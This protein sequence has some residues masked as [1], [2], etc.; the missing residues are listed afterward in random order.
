MQREKDQRIE[1]SL[2]QQAMER[3]TLFEAQ[4]ENRT[5][6]RIQS[7]VATEAHRRV[8]ESD[9]EALRGRRARL[10]ALREAE[11]S[12][13][14]KEM[15]SIV[16]TPAERKERLRAKA[17]ALKERREAERKAFVDEK[18]QQQWRESCDEAR[19]LDSAALL[20]YV[21]AER[22]KEIDDAETRKAQKNAE[23][24]AFAEQ[25]K[26]RMDD[27]AERERQDAEARR[28]A[29]LATKA[30]LDEQVRLK[31]ERRR[32]LIERM[33]GE[34]EEELSELAAAQEQERREKEAREAEARRRGHEVREFNAN[35]LDLREKRAAV[36]REQ[37]L[38]L[39]RYNMEREE[40]QL[41]RERAKKDAE[42]AATRQYH[43]YLRDL[44]VKEHQDESELDSIRRAEED[45][46]WVK[47]DQE[48][49]AQ[50]EARR[51]LMDI[52][53][54]GRREQISARRERDA[55]AAR[56]EAEQERR[57][58]E[59]L[60]KGLAQ[61]RARAEAR[62]RAQVE[63][64]RLLKEQIALR[65]RARQDGRARERKEAEDWRSEMRALD[66]RA[67]SQAGE[68]RLHHPKRHT[69]WYS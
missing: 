56:A 30:D 59:D 7:R 12:E 17:L 19:T 39:L 35:R 33:R 65:E 68:I 62:R 50:A 26:A 45:R 57:D 5:D 11:R 36:E 3:K 18:L 38:L 40:A 64:D 66:A 4:W 23:D 28:S 44:M 15:Q 14:V 2:R 1:E 46:I 60:Q 41:A 37:D 32:E 51:R 20:Q 24:A 6:Q 27:L 67:A 58:W 16:E 42:V 61:D 8:A 10:R 22:K 63:N 47:R 25:W 53:H 21:C 69:Q 48:Q 52:V 31:A 54:E 49:A 13:W 43:A 9:A 29:N 55:V 34:A